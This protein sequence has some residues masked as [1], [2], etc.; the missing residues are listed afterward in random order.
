MNNGIYGA[1][2]PPSEKSQDQDF[3]VSLT[4]TNVFSQK[5]LIIKILKLIFK[6]SVINYIYHVAL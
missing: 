2:A 6:L 3:R 5:I 1:G 4:T